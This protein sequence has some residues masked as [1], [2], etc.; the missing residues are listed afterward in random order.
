MR[1]TDGFVEVMVGYVVL[2]PIIYI[3]TYPGL[4]AL[5]VSPDR[6]SHIWLTLLTAI[7]CMGAV[8]VWEF[9]SSK[10]SNDERL[11]R[12]EPTVDKRKHVRNNGEAAHFGE[13][14]LRLSQNLSWRR[15]YEYT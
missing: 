7:H 13:H 8:L 4:T 3:L 6:T 5:L 15:T 9:S 10:T 14:V 12:T 1:G 11:H 2:F